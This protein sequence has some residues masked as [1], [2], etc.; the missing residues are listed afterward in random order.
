MTEEKK[1]NFYRVVTRWSAL[2]KGSSVF[3]VEAPTEEEAIKIAEDEFREDSSSEIGN[4]EIVMHYKIDSSAKQITE[5]S[6]YE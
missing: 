1:S 4:Y 5:E 3:R 2:V 6:Y